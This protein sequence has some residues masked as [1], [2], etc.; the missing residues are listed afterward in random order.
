M[1]IDLKNKRAMVCGASK[2]IGAATARELASLGASVTLVARNREALEELAGSLDTSLGQQHEWIALDFSD[3]EAV[4]NTVQSHVQSH[5]P[6]HILVNNSG[7]P[8]AGPASAASLDSFERAFTQHLLANQIF[9]QALVEG[10][11]SEN[12]GRVINIISTSVKQPIKGLGVSNTIR[13]AVAN[14][15]KTVATELAPYG[16]TVNNLLPGPTETDR[17]ME[18]Y[19]GKAERTGKTLEQVKEESRAEVPMGRFGQPEE[20]A[21]VIAFLACP[22]ASFVTGIN[23]PVDGGRTQCL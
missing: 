10:M 16:I 6:Y 11:K 20:V 8:P 7:G 5:G 22:A 14:W 4:Q 12:Y 2:G 18:L 15:A 9:L 13:G 17:L 3:T 21:Q 19:G 1:D 23:V